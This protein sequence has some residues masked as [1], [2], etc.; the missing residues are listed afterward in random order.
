MSFASREI[1]N[2]ITCQNFNR[3]FLSDFSK[4]KKK[5]GLT[6]L[7]ES[8]KPVLGLKPIPVPTPITVGLLQ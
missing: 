8:G 4:L 2:S 5:T 3:E 7:L 6:G 1:K